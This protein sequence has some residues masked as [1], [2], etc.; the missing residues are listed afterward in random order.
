VRVFLVGVACVG[1]TTIARA[2]AKRLGYPAFDLDD[3]VEKHFGA[4][5]ESLQRR[6]LTDYS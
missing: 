4:S 1:K 2:L 3:E 5:I 6:F